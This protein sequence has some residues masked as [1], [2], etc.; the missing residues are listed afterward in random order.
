[1][2]LTSILAL[3]AA[4]LFT[5]VAAA[6]P[7]VKQG[8]SELRHDIQVL[9]DAGIIRGAVTTWPLSWGDIA[10]GL[11]DPPDDMPLYVAAAFNRVKRRSF[12]EMKIGEWKF[13][14]RASATS[15]PRQIRTFEDTPREDTEVG[16]GV[17]WT[18]DLFAVRLNGEYAHNASDGDEWRLDGSYAGV[19]LGNWMLSV[20]ALDRWWGP[21]W[22]A[23]LILGNNARPIPALMLERNST[24]AFNQKWL[25]WIGTWDLTTFWGQLGDDAAVPDAN[26]FGLR[27]NFRPLKSLEVGLSRTAQMCGDGRPCSLSTFFDMLVG[28]DNVGEGTT[29]EE[30]PGNQLAGYDVRWSNTMTRQPF[31]LYLQIIGE[32]LNG[33][34][35]SGEFPVI[36]G[37]TWGAWDKL[38]SYRFYV[39][40]TDTICNWQPADEHKFNCA[41][42][43]HIYTDG[44]RYKGKVIGSPFDNDARV[45]TLGGVLIDH[46]DRS[47][48]VNA[49]FGVLNRGDP[50]DPRN[51]VA[52]VAT[53][54]WEIEVSHKRPLWIGE[55]YAGLGYDYRKNT[56]TNI[57][58]G[59]VR[60]FF[61]WRLGY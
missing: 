9:A 37:E 56:V 6:G 58:D 5:T 38:G 41:Y 24:R 3:F 32:D 14:A 61:E 35:P 15:D 1:L 42:N 13:E 10:T 51:T 46:K 22:Q 43:H 55:A 4:G 44:Y 33:W 18:G 52:S 29:P 23:S 19:S 53:D 47:W 60:V 27:I 30:E 26:L 59:D 31:A 2:K 49:A 45:T 28:N 39:E 8:S 25:A 17:N 34:R 54:Y 57:S 40:W 12:E 36:G 7:W 48:L 50:P 20:S 21:G 16:V 11:Q